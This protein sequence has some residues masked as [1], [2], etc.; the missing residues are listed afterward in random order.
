MASSAVIHSRTDLI[1]F[2]CW[3]IVVDQFF[4]DLFFDAWVFLIPCS[5]WFALNMYCMI[6]LG[7]AIVSMILTSTSIRIHP[8]AMHPYPLYIHSIAFLACCSNLASKNPSY[9][10]HLT[11]GPWATAAPVCFGRDKEVGVADDGGCVV[12]S[13]VLRTR[14]QWLVDRGF[15]YKT[16]CLQQRQM[17]L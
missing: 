7:R 12:H 14:W 6:H 4:S 17:I 10:V 13:V 8:K 16:S 3:S 15:R 11:L 5:I 1:Y 9:K 2:F